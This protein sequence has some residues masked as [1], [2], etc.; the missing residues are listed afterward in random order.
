MLTI[1]ITS[2]IT[3]TISTV[4]VVLFEKEFNWIQ[5]KSKIKYLLNKHLP[6]GFFFVGVGTTL[7]NLLG[8]Y[9]VNQTNAPLAVSIAAGNALSVLVNYFGLRKLFDGHKDLKSVFRYVASFISYYFLSV[10][11]MRLLSESL[12]YEI[13]SRAA[14]ITVLWPINYWVQKNLVFRKFDRVS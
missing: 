11:L 10:L 12:V 8:F 13:V 4:R 9:F 14:V 6:I 1:T 3:A 5:R 7:T 2:T